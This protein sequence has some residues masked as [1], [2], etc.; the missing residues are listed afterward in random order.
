MTGK[1]LYESIFEKRKPVRLTAVKHQLQQRVEESERLKTTVQL[2]EKEID[3]KNK[4]IERINKNV[5]SHKIE[6]KK[7]T[8][9][10]DNLMRQLSKCKANNIS[11]ENVDNEKCDLS[12]LKKHVVSV[13]KSLLAAVGAED[14]DSDLFESDVVR[15]R[16]P[17]SPH[18]R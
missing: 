2:L 5:S 9:A 11:P 1:L 8:E 6:I 12:D 10:N 7:L 15:N 4:E 18:F 3:R 14:D 17:Q 13:A 16:S